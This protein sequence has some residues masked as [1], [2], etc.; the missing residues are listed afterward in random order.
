M[1]SS[2]LQT[3]IKKKQKNVQVTCADLDKYSRVMLQKPR[4]STEYWPRCSNILCIVVYLLRAS[5]LGCLLLSDSVILRRLQWAN[6]SSLCRR[7]HIF[8]L[9]ETLGWARYS[10]NKE[11]PF[12]YFR[13]ERFPLGC[14]CVRVYT[15]IQLCWQLVKILIAINGELFIFL[16]VNHFLL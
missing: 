15:H 7:R 10:C 13:R 9:L 16:I 5:R 8:S 1:A 14:V 12:C 6:N 11:H 2:K 3:G 4:T